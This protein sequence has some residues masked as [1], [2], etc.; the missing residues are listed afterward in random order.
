MVQLPGGPG[1]ETWRVLWAEPRSRW[2]LFSLVPLGGGSGGI[3]TMAL[4][5]SPPPG[6]GG[7]RTGRCRPADLLRRSLFSHVVVSILQRLPPKAI[8]SLCAIYLV[9][10][11]FLASCSS[12][13]D[14]YYLWFFGFWVLGASRR[15]SAFRVSPGPHFL[16]SKPP[17]IHQVQQSTLQPLAGSAAFIHTYIHTYVLVHG[18]SI[19][20]ALRPPLSLVALRTTSIPRTRLCRLPASAER[21]ARFMSWA[22]HRKTTRIN[23]RWESHHTIANRGDES[24]ETGLPRHSGFCRESPCKQ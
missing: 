18:P 4:C 23:D 16:A 21:V 20:P 15:G 11:L 14:A 6:P 1:R 2:N 7:L 13:I 10:S 3:N 12:C 5:A 24:F 8:L 17:A 19:K 22:S 9:L